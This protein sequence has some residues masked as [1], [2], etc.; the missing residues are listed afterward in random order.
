[1]YCIPVYCMKCHCYEPWSKE[2]MERLL[3][4][5]D[6]QCGAN[7]LLCTFESTTNAR[8]SFLYIERII[9]VP[10]QHCQIT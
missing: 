7:V 6:G 5:N 4:P 8:T 1:M 3:E 10:W 9:K 2:W